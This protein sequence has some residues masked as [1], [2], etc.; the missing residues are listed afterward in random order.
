MEIDLRELT[1]CISLRLRRAART[2]THIYDQEL[3]AAGLTASQFTL[4]A[5]LYSANRD[6][7]GGVSLGEFAK[8][9]DLDPTTLNRRLKPLIALQLIENNFDSSDRRRR[10]L[11][12]TGSGMSLLNDAM[13]LWRQA[14]T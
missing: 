12:L 14:E 6:E 9:I 1:A 7:V 13:P 10:I 2:V 4:L 5:Q 3:K 11:L 8:L